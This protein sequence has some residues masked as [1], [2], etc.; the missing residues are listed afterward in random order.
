[1]NCL[2]RGIT[3]YILPDL[4]NDLICS[5]TKQALGRIY[6]KCRVVFEAGGLPAFKLFPAIQG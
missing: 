6:A 2:A 3:E 4:L 1:M 5:L